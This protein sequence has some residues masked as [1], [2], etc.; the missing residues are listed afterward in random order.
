M[1]FVTLGQVTKLF[2]PISILCAQLIKPAADASFIFTGMNLVLIH[3]V[4]SKQK[5]GMRVFTNVK[6]LL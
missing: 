5:E 1:Q 2:S 4:N 3:P 6:L